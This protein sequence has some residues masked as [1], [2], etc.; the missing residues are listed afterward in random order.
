MIA[1]RG[2]EAD[3][4]T[5]LHSARSE[6]ASVEA[7]CEALLARM[8]EWGLALAEA[9]AE[10]GEVSI[11]P[12]YGSGESTQ[13]VECRSQPGDVAGALAAMAGL[14][15]GLRVENRSLE[16]QIHDINL[17]M[18][19]TDCILADRARECQALHSELAAV[20]F[21]GGSSIGGDAEPLGRSH[22]HLSPPSLGLDG[23]F[24][25][26][27][28]AGTG[29]SPDRPLLTRAVQSEQATCLALER[30]H[31][32][33]HKGPAQEWTK[34]VLE[35]AAQESVRDG[36]AL[37]ETP[38]W[39]E[40]VGAFSARTHCAQSQALPS[41]SATLLTPARGRR[42]SPAEVRALPTPCGSR[43]NHSSAGS[44]VTPLQQTPLSQSTRSLGEAADEDHV[45]GSLVRPIRLQGWASMAHPSTTSVSGSS[46][47]PPPP[48]ASPRPPA[49]SAAISRPTHSKL[50]VADA[51]LSVDATRPPA[52]PSLYV[53]IATRQDER[54]RR[55]DSSHSRV[56]AE[57]V[58]TGAQVTM[59]SKPPQG[60]CDPGLRHRP[61]YMEP[62]GTR[63]A[64]PCPR[65][66]PRSA[67]LGDQDPL[68]RALEELRRAKCAVGFFPHPIA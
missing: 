49:P 12:T 2:A 19:D 36:N 59:S 3:A 61:P 22:E 43:R 33:Q 58:G 24:T 5:Q 42:I 32:H 65:E 41:C 28:F 53:S 60:P 40:T 55:A 29:E 21:A 64:S 1:A 56:C 26:E 18:Q 27:E 37:R 25:I 52:P 34:L 15:R 54:N 23:I 31:M 66:E 17:R 68:H 13:Y 67:L 30:K 62:C 8:Q 39:P 46:A 57:L 14:I 9:Q 16:Q 4:R 11:R 63:A 50:P 48:V 38:R 6:L 20:R 35:R 47:L 7:V 10:V 45:E 44:P 51:S